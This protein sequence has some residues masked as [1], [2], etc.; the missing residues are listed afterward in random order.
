MNDP[1]RTPED[2]E[3]FIIGTIRNRI[4]TIPAFRAHIPITNTSLQISSI[5]VYL[6][7]R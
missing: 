3:L 7:L 2:Y 1:L 6:H 5:I 4:Q